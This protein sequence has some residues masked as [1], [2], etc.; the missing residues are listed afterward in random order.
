MGKI[1]KNQNAASRTKGIRSAKRLQ[2]LGS[3]QSQAV[4]FAIWT[5]IYAEFF[6]T[7][8][9]Y[10]AI[11][12]HMSGSRVQGRSLFFHRCRNLNFNFQKMSEFSTSNREKFISL[13]EKRV[14]KALQAI[15]VIG[16][17]SN[18]SNYSYTEED[19]K[20]IKKA[21]NT[22]LNETI[23]RFSNASGKSNT[24]SLK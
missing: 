15:S 18:K 7:L 5:D 2:Q 3:R 4:Y 24:F 10:T 20:Q 17:L 6:L 12:T 11:C 16:N 9:P 1:N 22:Q 13:A 23:A 8:A 21:L 19:V 14:Q